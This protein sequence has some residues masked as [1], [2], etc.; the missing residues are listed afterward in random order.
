MNKAQKG[1]FEKLKSDF[2]EL[3]KK[4]KL[5]AVGEE[6]LNTYVT[7]MLGLFAI[8]PDLAAAECI[9]KMISFGEENG[10]AMYGHQIEFDRLKKKHKIR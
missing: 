10:L 3:K 6:D 5:T 9:D 2:S 7:G 1:V 4:G 8:E